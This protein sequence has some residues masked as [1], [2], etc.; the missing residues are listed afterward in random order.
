MSKKMIQTVLGEIPVENMGFVLPHEHVFCAVPFRW[1]DLDDCTSRLEMEWATK[2]VTPDMQTWLRTHPFSNFDNLIRLE[3]Q[4]SLEE[5]QNFKNWGGCTVVDVTPNHGYMFKKDFRPDMQ[6]IAKATGLN[7][8]S[9]TGYMADDSGMEHGEEKLT[10]DELA[11]I[12]IDEIRIGEP[13]TGIK[14]G[15]I[16]AYLW[17]PKHPMCVKYLQACGIAQRETGVPIYVHP[18]LMHETNNIVL[19]VLEGVGCDLTKVV[20]CHCGPLLDH[21]DYQKALLDRGCYLE[22]D[23]CGS[24]I[25]DNSKEV[26][27]HF[28]RDIDTIRLLKKYVEMGYE[29]QLLLSMDCCFKNHLEKY[30][31]AG[32]AHLQK[33]YLPMMKLEG[34]TDEVL[35]KLTVEN[36]RKLYTRKD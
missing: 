21:F 23:E 16:K 9:C 15:C 10:V 5:L 17:D 14:A 29:D 27:A 18:D 8:I 35:Y 3:Y 4:D 33:N 11:Q 22:H 34:F 12:L 1:L 19:D 28:P 20:L 6:R 26:L 30:G 25:F 24:E 13:E 2:R 32:Y 31:G 36:P 7:I